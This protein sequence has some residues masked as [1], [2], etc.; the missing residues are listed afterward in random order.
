MENKHYLIFS[1]Y[2]LHYGVDALLVQEIFHL[3]ELTTIAE[4]PDDI[5]GILNLRGQ[6]VPVMHLALR[7]GYQPQECSLSDSVIVLEWEGLQIGIVV[8]SVHEV[9]N[10]ADEAIEAEISYGRKREINSR[11]ISGVA[12]VDADIIMLLNHEQLLCYSDAVSAL[13][14]DEDNNGSVDATNGYSSKQNDT[15]EDQFPENHHSTKSRIGS[16]YDLCCPNASPEDRKIFRERSENLRQA[17]TNSDF[18]GL[19]PL[20]VIGLNGEYFGLDLEVVREFTNIRNLTPI[21]CCPPHIVGNMNLRGEI[22]TL[23]DIRQALNLPSAADKVSQAI[24]IRVD[25][26]VAG[27]PVDRVFDVMYLHPKDVTPVPVAV[28]SGSNEYLRGTAPYSEKMLSILD[29]PKII[30]KGELAVND[31]F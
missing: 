9:K 13:L 19:M 28:H 1:L 23:V 6:I 30:S 10:I 4:A 29:L 2:G 16:F 5:V 14:P 22:V 17:T 21:P 27:L 3:A 15:L 11:F 7:L 18:T 25:D 8:N 12:K 24:V 31:E 26:V 20:A